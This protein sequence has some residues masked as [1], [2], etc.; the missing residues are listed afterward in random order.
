M[1]KILL[2]GTGLMFSLAIVTTAFAGND[3]TDGAK[4]CKS[5]KACAG[6]CTGKCDGKCTGKKACTKPETKSN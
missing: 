3:K 1:K 4:Q 6:K 5:S 2:Y